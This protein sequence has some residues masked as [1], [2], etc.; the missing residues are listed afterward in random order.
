MT[1]GNAFQQSTS[2]PSRPA[3]K[4]CAPR[5]GPDGLRGLGGVFNVT[6]LHVFNYGG[7]NPVKYV[8]PDG[9]ALVFSQNR[10]GKWGVLTD[11]QTN[12]LMLAAV[13]VFVPFVPFASAGITSLV[14]RMAGTRTV[15]WHFGGSALGTFGSSL[16]A[17]GTYGNFRGGARFAKSAGYVSRIISIANL[18]Y[19]LFEN[20]SQINQI[21]AGMFNQ[22]IRS[23]SFEEALNRFEGF[24]QLVTDLVNFG[25]IT[26]TTRRGRAIWET[27]NERWNEFFDNSGKSFLEH[28]DRI[29]E[30]SRL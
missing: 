17:Y 15:T 5:Q 14:D 30:E 19:E 2:P 28:R 27:N 22:H 26:F 1:L 9:E 29:L 12:N 6:N 18:G 21:T 10:A 3:R 11:N 25:A 16:G 8:D 13:D 4:P 20:T 23:Y 24:N 7:N